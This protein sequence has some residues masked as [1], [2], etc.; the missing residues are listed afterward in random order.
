VRKSIYVVAALI[1]R[2]AKVL[3]DLRRRGSHLEGRWEFPGGKREIG[4]TDEQAL[5]RELREE[6]GIETEVEG[7]PIAVVEHAYPELDVTLALY[8]VRFSGEPIAKDVEAIGW[9]SFDQLR[10]LEMPPADVPLVDA[11]VAR[12]AGGRV[13]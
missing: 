13:R 1:E 4:E 7:P 3:L 9:F 5:V 2:D 11:V 10:G 8:A 12:A 6:L